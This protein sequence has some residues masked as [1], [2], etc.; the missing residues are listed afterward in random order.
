MI[1]PGTKSLSIDV[2][3]VADVSSDLRNITT[4]FPMGTILERVELNKPG[5]PAALPMPS[6]NPSS[7]RSGIFSCVNSDLSLPSEHIPS[8]VLHE[9]L[10]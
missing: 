8:C 6:R 2:I 4:I 5:K 9:L 1:D 7:L 3:Q 10:E